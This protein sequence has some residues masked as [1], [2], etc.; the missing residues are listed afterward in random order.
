M[1]KN[2]ANKTIE[3][4]IDASAALPRI[5]NERIVRQ[6]ETTIHASIPNSAGDPGPNDKPIDMDAVNTSATRSP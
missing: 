1:A 2:H 5:T 3:K 4:N 6:T